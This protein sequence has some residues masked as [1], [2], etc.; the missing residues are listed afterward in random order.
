MLSKLLNQTA[1]SLRPKLNIS[2]L[3][4]CSH[5]LFQPFHSNLISIELAFH[6]QILY[7]A[8]PPVFNCTTSVLCAHVVR[9]TT[10]SAGLCARRSE[11]FPS[12]LQ[13]YFISMSQQQAWTQPISSLEPCDKVNS[14]RVEAGP[15]SP[16]SRQISNEGVSWRFSK[17]GAGL[18]TDTE[19]KRKSADL[20]RGGDLVGMLQDC[21][22][23]F[24]CLMMPKRWCHYWDEGR[25]YNFCVK[26]AWWCFLC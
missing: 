15:G 11:R 21:N 17:S 5:A 8:F 18:A 22:S 13:L 4:M 20:P 26:I 9:A 14:L 16:L 3:L 1:Y 6:E 12:E 10:C 24:V 25:E 19:T 2:Q 23:T 7:F